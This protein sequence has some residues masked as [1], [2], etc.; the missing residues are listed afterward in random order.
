MLVGY[1]TFQQHVCISLE[2]ICS[3]KFTFCHTETEV[4][5]QT[6]YLAQ[7]RCID[8]G[9]TNPCADPFTPGAWQGSHWSANFEVTGM[10]RPGETP[11]AKAGIEPRTCRSRDGRLQP[12][13]HSVICRC[14]GLVNFEIAEYR[15][16][17]Y[18]EFVST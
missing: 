6:F 2:Q 18:R 3:D 5:D 14:P 7:S 8:T 4:A 12:F 13:Q 11:T 15:R 10:T 9:P 17:H 16:E 1:L